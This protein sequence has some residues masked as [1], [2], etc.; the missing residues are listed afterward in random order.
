MAFDEQ[1]YVREVLEPARHNGG[2][3]TTDLLVRYGLS[4]P[5]DSR[6]V[7]TV[8]P[9]VLGC[10]RRARRELKYRKVV[11]RLEADHTKLAA[12]F[13]KAKAG[14]LAPLTAV[15]AAAGAVDQ[16][17]HQQL[18][19][20]VADLA[21]PVAR[22]TPQLATELATRHGVDEADVRA[23]LAEMGVT[24]TTADPL[25]GAPPVSGY[26]R[27][28]E[29][30][31]TL[32][33]RHTADLLLQATG[34]TPSEGI[35]LWPRA[36]V[37]AS[38]ER[39]DT[40]AV[41]IAD[42]AWAARPHDGTRTLAS[43]VLVTLKK[44]V[45]ASG[46]DGIT[47]LVRYE[48]AEE[49]RPRHRQ[50]SSAA[51]L[52]RYATDVL[53]LAADDARR[54]VFAVRAE[55]P[56]PTPSTNAD[57]AA[58]QAARDERDRRPAANLT[59]D[60]PST[61]P[62]R[63]TDAESAVTAPRSADRPRTTAL[64]APRPRGPLTADPPL[65]LPVQPGP[66]VESR[67]VVEAR[68][69]V[70]PR[71]AVEPYSAP[72]PRAVPPHSTVP[73]TAAH[74]P[75]SAQ[76]TAGAMAVES[77]PDSPDQSSHADGV[78]PARAAQRHHPT[79]SPSAWDGSTL[80]VPAPRR[81]IVER[82]GAEAVVR[83]EW[84]PDL[85]EVVLR[86]QLG[87]RPWRTTT[88][89]RG[90]YLSQGGAWL[91]SADPATEDPS[92]DL[93]IEL[94]PV[95]VRDGRRIVGDPVTAQAPGRTSL[96]YEVT[97]TGPP[98]R[99]DLAVHVHTHRP[100]RLRQLAVV[101]RRGTVMPLHATDGEVLRHLEDVHLAPDRPVRLRVPAPRGPYWVRCFVTADDVELSDPPVSQLR[102]R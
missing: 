47:N 53:G 41:A 56:V 59:A 60:P 2:I 75:A 25:P 33:C 99:R 12:A 82:S 102:G 96:W 31:R 29:A 3:P 30:L 101:L 40:E 21:A 84:P 26:R 16:A 78:H 88:V 72:E 85:T 11:A 73:A 74:L 39:L 24:V 97:R 77:V 68:S 95:V 98:W 51:A 69:P 45:A 50:G 9:Q 27:Y 46:S 79:G 20:D 57:Q 22:I 35:T 58:P 38:A 43:T 13:E 71:S 66:V 67:S 42:R 10:W 61:L 70:E 36:G 28:R 19:A 7:A 80:S 91:A 65:R 17:I 44:L 5:L 83:W 54:I 8:L 81:P 64:P 15:I 100:V 87:D 34:R 6:Q 86:W 4:L 76:P 94:R 37:A 63:R 23:V 62:E 14:D 55:P 32:G 52:V 92:A 1:R 90:A 49:L 93:R 89:S 18:R 48:I